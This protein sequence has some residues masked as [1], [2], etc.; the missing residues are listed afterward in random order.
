LSRATNQS[1][2]AECEKRIAAA[3][4]TAASRLDLSGL[5]LEEWPRSLADLTS[6]YNLDLSKN[7]LVSIPKTLS[8]FS[9]LLTLDLSGNQITELP[10]E[11]SELSD[12]GWLNVSR[13]K[14]KSLPDSIVRLGQL[15][16]LDAANNALSRLPPGFETL[17]RLTSLRVSANQL[18]ELPESL[19]DLARLTTLAVDD[20]R[21]RTLPDSI[22]SLK[23][24]EYLDLTNNQLSELPPSIAGL[25]LREFYLHGNPGLGI[26]PEILGAPQTPT[27]RSRSAS[28]A[29]AIIDY[30]C[31]IL[32]SGKPLNEAKLILVGRGGVGKTSIVNRLVDGTF[33][34]DEQKTDGIKITDWRF[35]LHG[36]ENIRL[37]VWD[38]GGQEIMHATHQFF[39]S[40]RSLYLLIL[41]GREGSADSD[42][43]YW[44][45]LI[46]SFGADSPIV[47]VLNKIR[48]HPFDLNRRGLQQKYPSIRAF[49]ETDCKLDVGIDGLRSTVQQETDRL[50]HLRDAFP[51]S[52]F[53]IKNRVARMRE[54]FVSFERFRAICVEAGERDPLSQERLAHYLHI[55]GIA[56]NYKDDPRLQD[57]HV[58][59]PHWVTNGI[60]KILNSDA[61][62]STRGELRLDDLASILDLADYPRQKHP[63]LIDLMRKFDLCFEF[64][65]ALDRFLIPE[66]L[67]KEEPDEITSMDGEDYLRF[68]YHYSVF[69]EGILPRFIVR[70]QSLSA[71]RP[72]WRTGVVLQFEG[73]SAL[74]KADVQERRVFVSV[75]GPADSRRRLLAIVRADFER[76]HADI[77]RLEV[78]EMVPIP[79]RPSVAVPYRALLVRERKGLETIEVDT[80]DDVLI[81]PIEPLLNGVDLA[82][83]R[84]RRGA[85]VNERA[86]RLFFSYAHE[87]EWWRNQ[88]EQHLKLLQRQG[89][90]S[91]WHD[92]RIAPGDDWAKRI[93]ENLAAADIVIMLLSPD[94]IASEYI[95]QEEMT[96]ALDRH[97]KGGARII[98]VILRTCDWQ[99][100]PL[101]R[102]QC[103]PASGEAITQA[104]DPDA[105]WVEV[106]T[107]VREA[108][109]RLRPRA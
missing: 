66:L 33:D 6:L 39:L 28:D 89:L 10:R 8:T 9:V 43:E 78:K 85:A 98:P 5:D 60:Y 11:I 54:N 57:T 14:L 41:S 37:N 44:L 13:N 101:G 47:V 1:N 52:W 23:A 81:Q 63:F 93:D 35:Q 7:R 99:N 65:D 51:A 42:A 61:V 71:A 102:L 50:E 79:G 21:L 108:A 86:V 103:V 70:T 25:D 18:D 16:E 94:F 96:V 40:Q 19:G 67:S 34:P 29:A 83:E 106:A 75:A 90:V 49:V 12:L 100:T 87:D 45:K 72:R 24:L 74:V 20:N 55:L 76:I 73:C 62:A 82:E 97:Q 4:R 31:R 26:P 109:P 17:K 91:I 107:A 59:N 105:A 27:P 92:R 36:Y 15:K 69:P 95:F 56:L 88:L 46:E 3:R 32:A 30:Y 77:A 22:G 80:Q 84:A 64:P 58:L 104:V 68:E 48:Q 38:F 53:S 2:L